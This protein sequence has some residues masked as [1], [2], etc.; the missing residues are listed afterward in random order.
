MT[1]PRFSIVLA[2]GKG[3]RMLSATCHKVC[4]PVDGVP[5]INRALAIYTRSGIRQHIV[6]V[7]AMAGQVIET[8]RGAFPDV[9]FARQAEAS[10]T[11]DAA[12]AGLLALEGIDPDASLLLAAGD[13]I[14]D[15]DVLGQLF[16]L[17]CTQGLDLALAVSPGPPGSDRGRLVESADGAPLAVVEDADLRQRQVFR[18]LRARA[19]EGTLSAAAAKKIIESEFSPPQA[20]APERKLAAAFGELWTAVKEGRPAEELL[21]LVP[22]G[23]E[24]FRFRTA[25]G[26]GLELRP[27]EVRRGRWLNN[28]IYVAKAS[29]L[30]Y[31]LDRLGRDNAQKEEYL[32][33]IVEVLAGAGPR[34]KVG[35][36]RVERPDAILGYNNPAELLAVETI[37]QERRA[38]GEASS[39]PEGVSFRPLQGWI[40][41]FSEA[42]GGS[43]ALEIELRALY[44]GEPAILDERRAAF[45]TL[46]AKAATVMD[47]ESRVLLVRS[48]GRLNVMGR[49][50]DHQ[51]GTCNLMTIGFETLLAV[52]PRRDDLI[53][54]FNVDCERFPDRAFSISEMVAGLPWNDWLSLVESDKA[55]EMA[56]EA[57]G[58][59]S[60]YVKAA[61][62]RLQKKFPHRRLQGMDIVVSGNIP[63]AA[64]LSSSSSLVVAVAEATI[65]V[66]RLETVPAEFVDL[67]GEGEWFAGTRGGSADHAAIRL[68]RKGNVIKV[69]FCE[70]AVEDAVP[71][72][73]GHVMAVV[74]SG[75]RAH[76]SGSARDQFN[77]RIA[78]YGLGL[79]LIRKLHPAVAPVLRHLRD[80][81]VRTLGLPLEGIYRILLDLPEQATRAE[82]EALLPEEDL[83]P[84]WASH[85]EPGDG[86]YP[87]RG[88]VL[89]GLAECERARLYA[90]CLRS[91]R[92]DEIGR[93][94]KASH[95]G[96]RV[97]VWSPAG[98][99]GPFRAPTSDTHLRQLAEDLESRE[100][101]RIERAQLAWQPGCYAC[102]LPVLD[103]MVD[104]SAATEG[105]AGAQLAGAGLGGCLM[106]LARREA[107][108]AL[109]AN[110]EKAAA[111]TPGPAPAVLAC[112]P[113][114]GAGLLFG[115]GRAPGSVSN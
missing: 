82:L 14:I 21:R 101:D 80:V 69:A 88:V 98:E 68:G 46:L 15:P 40:D 71:F 90:D 34:F 78:C 107:V 83:R 62:L 53:R 111:A 73:D 42:A 29:A 52:R 76:K 49:H 41:I 51:G 2:A 37:L 87:I 109:R 44:G 113:I 63:P 93:M 100:P 8:V 31:A 97:A 104:I 18:E 33:G 95:D 1:G 11:A 3:S 114:A 4:F 26:T 7:G 5:A 23:R 55:R 91:G 17:F 59:W 103:R 6:V 110:L 9:V 75:V 70:F 57:G 30:R 58:D 86:L 67:C 99:A 32:S 108:P 72:P 89:F 94:M 48:P 24:S 19:A 74:D 85:Q 102:S 96:D 27:D 47:P 38:G 28:S 12:R 35:A 54:L 36:L 56:R 115:A 39:L 112:L 16:D 77:H 65:A 81:N 79:R 22:E 10:G 92:I 43:S 66:N 64:G 60:Q 84:L 25:G 105:V 20:P 13:R 61:V 106:V 50:I 45:R